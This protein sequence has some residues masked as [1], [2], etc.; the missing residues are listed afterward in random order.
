[1]WLVEHTNRW[2]GTVLSQQ[3]VGWVLLVGMSATSVVSCVKPLHYRISY[4]ERSDVWSL[5]CVVLE[6]ATC[7][8]LSVRGIWVS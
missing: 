6:L 8:F 5:G 7:S 4:D 3:V 1:M 2:V